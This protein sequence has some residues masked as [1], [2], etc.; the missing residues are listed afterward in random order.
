MYIV[1]RYSSV[2]GTLKCHNTDIIATVLSLIVHVQGL[3]IQ[4]NHNIA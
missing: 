2:E 4:C 3:F 1:H